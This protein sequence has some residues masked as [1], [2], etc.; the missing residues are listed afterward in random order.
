MTK[1]K[2]WLAVG[3]IGVALA[4]ADLVA[5]FGFGRD[6]LL[7]V[8]VHMVIIVDGETSRRDFVIPALVGAVVALVGFGGFFAARRRRIGH[9]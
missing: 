9:P 8:H 6:S 4:L 5:R 7:G 2:I 3:I 1:M